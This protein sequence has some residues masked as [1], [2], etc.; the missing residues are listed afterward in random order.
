MATCPTDARNLLVDSIAPVITSWPIDAV[1]SPDEV[2]VCDI[3]SVTWSDNCSVSLL[4]GGL[5]FRF[6]ALGTPGQTFTAVDECG[7]SSSVQQNILVRTLNHLCLSTL[8]SSS[9]CDNPVEAP[10]AS[11][12]SDRQPIRLDRISEGMVG[13]LRLDGDICVHSDG[14]LREPCQP[15]TRALL[16]TMNHHWSRRIC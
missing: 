9:T 14:R 10:E 4:C 7:N 2:P 13:R 6:T 5:D 11:T 12:S 3:D 15:R 1:N 16:Q 8:R